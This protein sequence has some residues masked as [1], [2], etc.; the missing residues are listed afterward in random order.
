[1]DEEQ[2]A[3]ARMERKV[4]R[5]GLMA[6][7]AGGVAAAMLKLV[8]AGR[9]QA[10]H[11]GSTPYSSV[12][13][14]HV[15]VTN[16]GGNVANDETATSLTLT[17]SLVA[18]PFAGSVSVFRA[19]NLTNGVNQVCGL[20]GISNGFGVIG[21]QVGG[22]NNH[23]T[24]GLSSGVAG[25]GEGTSAS[26]VVGVALASGAGVR[27]ESTSGIGMRGASG[28]NSTGVLG[29]SNSGGS[30]TANGNGS[31]VGVEGRSASGAGVKGTSTSGP[32]IDGISTN[33][34][35]IRGTSTN[36]VG[37]VGISTSSHGLYGS[38]NSASSAGVVAENL[39]GGN[40]LHVTGNAF[41][42]GNLQVTGAKNAVIKM[43]DG[44]EGVV[45]CQ[46][47]PEPY[48]EDFGEARLVDGT[49]QVAL[50]PEFAALVAGGKYMVFS[51]P[52]GDTRGLYV[53]RQDAKGFEVRECQGGTSSIP[54][55]YRVVTKRKDIEGKRF[56][57]ISEDAKTSVAAARAQI[58]NT[59]RLEPQD[60][61]TERR[62]PR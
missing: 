15:G 25:S 2:E 1:V 5:R 56:A 6:G 61:D 60:R 22:F 34:L 12:N 11:D 51:F 44:T 47:A 57:R 29:V 33:S 8:G 58:S 49:A 16:D 36:F 7:I 41:I 62:G 48:F 3:P 23:P 18:A 35:G 46:E 38:T 13:T 30:F 9:V 19:R 42:A 39:A 37:I 21:R 27:G 43:P 24:F 32:G 31:G 28:G 10:D 14:M 53:S 20:E 52:Q 55:T 54:F 4:L 59:P 45:Y 40:G 26:G 50:E 17:T